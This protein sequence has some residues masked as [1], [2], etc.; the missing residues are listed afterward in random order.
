MPAS[1]PETLR[2]GHCRT[3]RDCGHPEISHAIPCA[4]FIVMV[5][6][7]R[8]SNECISIIKEPG[9]ELHAE[10]G[11]PPAGLSVALMELEGITCEIWGVFGA[12]DPREEAG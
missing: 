8:D 10:Y 2:E 4:L 12:R 3:S 11:E 9:R 7:P 1:L 5:R 6:K